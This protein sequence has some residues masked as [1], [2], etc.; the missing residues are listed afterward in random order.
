VLAVVLLTAFVFVESRV[1]DPLLP[2]RVVADRVRGG[3]FL[4]LGISAA[5]LFAVFLFVTYYMRL[6]KGVSPIETGLAYLRMTAAI[7]VS[8]TL[9]TTRF[10]DK[11]GPRPLLVLALA[12]GALAM[13]CSHSYTPPRATPATCCPA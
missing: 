4:A 13:V 5:A 2:L 11:V 10:L 1:H 3:S 8:A 7:M 12:P 9:A 6:T